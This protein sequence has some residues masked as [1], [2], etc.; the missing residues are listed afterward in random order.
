MLSSL[1]FDTL[2]D[3]TLATHRGVNNPAGLVER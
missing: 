1:S 2:R 3:L